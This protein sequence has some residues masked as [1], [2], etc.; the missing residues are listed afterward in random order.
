[1]DRVHD[2]AD[3]HN[4]LNARLAALEDSGKPD[5]DQLEEIIGTL[6]QRVDDHENNSASSN[7]RFERLKSKVHELHGR[8]L[9]NEQDNSQ[10]YNH[11]RHIIRTIAYNH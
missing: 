4:V 9:T 11:I 10:S 7:S 2:L 3:T 6:T 8:V 1:M 5:V